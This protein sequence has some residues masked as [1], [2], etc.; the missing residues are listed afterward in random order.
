MIDSSEFY[1][2]S[3][4]NV[5]QLRTGRIIYYFWLTHFFD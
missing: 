3:S 2:D 4:V 5:R 1:I